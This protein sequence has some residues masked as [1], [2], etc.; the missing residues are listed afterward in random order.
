MENTSLLIKDTNMSEARI[1]AKVL[2]LVSLVL[3][4]TPNLFLV[5]PLY[6]PYER[7]MIIIMAT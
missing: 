3:F 6:L 1:C 2:L 7:V 5:V 4:L